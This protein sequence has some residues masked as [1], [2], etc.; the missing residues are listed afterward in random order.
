MTPP[1]KVYLLGIC[2][3]AMAALAGLLKDQGWEVI[4]SD[5]G[6]YPPMS[7]FLARQGIPVLEGYEA[8]HLDQVKPDLVVVGNVIRRENP[9]AQRMFELNLKHLS[10]PEAV[11]RWFLN[12]RQSVVVAGTHGKTTAAALLA[13]LLAEAGGDPSFLIGGICRNFDS[14]YKLGKGPYFVIEGDEY[15]TAFFDKVPKFMHYQPFW[16]ILGHVEYDHADI[17]PDFEAVKTALARFVELIPPP[18]RMLVWA[19]D[20]TTLN[21]AKGAACPVIPYGFGPEAVIKAREVKLGPKEVTFLLERGGESWGRFASPLPGRHNLANTL[22]ALGLLMEMGISPDKLAAGLGQFAG[23]KRR[24]EIIGRPG[25]V[26]IMDDFAHHPTAVRETLAALKPFYPRR[27]LVAVFEPR[28][29]TSRRRI[30]QNEYPKAFDA[31]DVV[32]V[33]RPPRLEGIPEAERFSSEKLVAA[34]RASG[35]EAYYF[36]DTEAILSF[37]LKR[38][39]PGDLIAILSNG[40]FDGLHARLHSELQKKYGQKPNKT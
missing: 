17:Y 26:L 23:V 9:E 36:P 4:G 27:R 18:G 13:W 34:L 16:V 29:N 11:G 40:G 8:W 1:T 25:D 15:D 22:A 35:R 10:L 2:G 38:A 33:R 32:L 30:F 12:S 14:S 3:T 19:D 37:L 28:T 20:P 24:Q 31:A 7:E 21:L 6:I 39:R 5:V